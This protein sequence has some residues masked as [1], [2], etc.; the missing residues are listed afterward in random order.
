MTFLSKQNRKP[1]IQMLAS[2]SQ[3][4]VASKEPTS[5]IRITVTRLQ[6]WAHK[7]DEQYQHWMIKHFDPIFGGSRQEQMQ[8]IGG[9]E[10]LL[11]INDEE[12]IFNRQIA[13]SSFALTTAV[14]GVRFFHP[15]LLLSSVTALYILYPIY[16]FAWKET[17]K[18]GQP[19]TDTLGAVEITGYFVGGYWVAAPLIAFCFNLSQKLV[20]NTEGRTRR[21]LVQVFGQQPRTVWVQVGE[22][23]VE[24]PFAQLQTGDVLVITAGQMIPVDGVIVQG[25]ASIDQ[26]MLTGEAQPAEKSAGDGVLAATVVL[27]GKILVQVEK[28]GE[29]TTAAQIVE[30]LNNSA[31]YTNALA[32]RGVE[33]ANR[34]AT[35]TLLLSAAALPT[36][37]LGGAVAVLT[38][39]FGFNMLL[40]SPLTMLN[41]LNIAARQRILVK[42][43]RALEQLSGVDTIVFDKTGTLTIEQPHVVQIHTYHD[44]AANDVLRYAAAAE[45]RQT[46]PIARAILTAA[47]EASL[48][49]P[50]IEDACYE[51]GYGI[52]VRIDERLIRVGSDRFMSMEAIALPAAVLDLKEQSQ[53]QGHSL[54]MIA[55]DQQLVGV[56]ELQPTLRP[57]AQALIGELHRRQLKTYII[58]G[59]QEGPTRKLAADLGIDGYFANTLPEQKASLVEQLQAEGRT[60]CFVGDGINDGV[61]LRKANVSISLRGATTVATDAAQIVFM[62]ADLRYLTTLLDLAQEFDQT[63][64]AGF[65]TTIIPGAICIG[66]VFFLHFGV[67][68]G[69]ALYNMG[70][71][72]GLTTAMSPLWRHRQIESDSK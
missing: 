43:G 8:E 12:K 10:A 33:I 40:I 46:H 4:V 28:T 57:E 22:V 7:V 66:G 48:P 42:D 36:V 69:I 30:L 29:A 64:K 52:K 23:E 41:L 38:S 6:D 17:K 70:L 63:M 62:D 26:H 21:N 51:I 39:G 68:A 27:A 32:L 44:W 9:R 15:L 31:N 1:L 20:R 67:Y 58:S 13:L 25:V 37:G 54:V 18:A 14:A 45:Q 16:Q 59:D 50:A 2:S 24:V 61:A 65:W 56:I 3:S 71:L 60:V 5:I 47:A 19:T 11:A 49:L 72:A 53:A 55:V 35:P 34:S